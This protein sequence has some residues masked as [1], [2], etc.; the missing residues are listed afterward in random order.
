M[1]PL[2][3]CLMSLPIAALG[4]WGGHLSGLPLGALIGVVCTV[5]L[6]GK[7]GLKMR[8]PLPFVATVQ[9]L[10]GLSAGCVAQAIAA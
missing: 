3:Q 4:A 5:T 8:M 10:L 2:L 1:N 7:L 6:A 9:L